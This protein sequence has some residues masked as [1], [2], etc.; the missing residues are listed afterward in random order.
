VPLDGYEK[1]QSFT[2]RYLL[3]FL[4]EVFGSGF[5]T[6]F[7]H[8]AEPASTIVVQR[9]RQS[10]IGSAPHLRHQRKRQHG[11]TDDPLAII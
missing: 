8:T 4:L 3:H 10:V 7:E 9:H 6:V 11:V 1:I 5:G 2:E